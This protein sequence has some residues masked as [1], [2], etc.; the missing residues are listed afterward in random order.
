MIHTEYYADGAPCECEEMRRDHYYFP[1][2]P[3][4]QESPYVNGKEHGITKEYNES[5]AL[6]LEV[7][8]IDGKEHGIER[9]YYKTG[10]LHME[11]PYTNGKHHGITKVYHESGVLSALSMHNHGD[12]CP[13]N[14]CPTEN[15]V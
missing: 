1:S 12:S 10:A 7:P 14:G 9:A 11:I 3:I 5:G 6:N 15:F 4:W 8:F 2:G 13:M